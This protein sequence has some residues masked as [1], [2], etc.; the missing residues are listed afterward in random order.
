[1]ED[2]RKPIT[3][4]M[5]LAKKLPMWKV[6]PQIQTL[7]E[8]TCFKH[9]LRFHEGNS[10]NQ[11]LSL[12][13]ALAYFYDRDESVFSFGD[14]KSFFVDFSLEDVL[15][16]TGLSIDGDPVTGV[17][18]VSAHAIAHELNIHETEV[19]ELYF[20]RKKAK[21]NVRLDLNKLRTRFEKV[22]EEC[23]DCDAYLKA[24][25]L[26]LLGTVIMPNNTEGVSPIY[27]PLLGRNTVNKYAWGAAMVGFLKNSLKD[28]K[29]LLDEGKTGSISGFVYAIMV[30]ALE[31]FA[32]V[33][34][35][36]CKIELHSWVIIIIPSSRVKEFVRIPFMYFLKAG[37]IAQAS[38]KGA[39]KALGYG[40]LGL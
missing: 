22:P 24:Y 26:Y 39:L 16:I 14:K 36:L 25:L 34:I 20:K 33:R 32:C 5:Q 38:T 40:G 27:L 6:D 2:Q 15:Y 11:N 1:M 9:F 28:T 10:V 37:I 13:T 7:V 12:L 3:N 18:N 31:R 21:T 30:F 23:L 4:N 29:A 35:Q 17:E 8:A 19:D